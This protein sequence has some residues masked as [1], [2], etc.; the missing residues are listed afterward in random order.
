MARVPRGGRPPG[1]PV[2]ATPV[3]L[4]AAAWFPPVDLAP[5]PGQAGPSSPQP[6][7]A[8]WPDVAPA[9][10]AVHQDTGHGAAGEMV[11][12]RLDSYASTAAISLA[13]VLLYINTLNHQFVYDDR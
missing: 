5:S 10:V 2:P 9:L 1:P 3:S 4:A 11:G 7:P 13:A 6:G 12:V 8:R